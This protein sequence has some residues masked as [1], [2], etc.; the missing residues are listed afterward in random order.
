MIGI[1]GVQIKSE[2][3][4]G[5]QSPVVFMAFHQDPAHLF[6]INADVIRPLDFWRSAGG[7]PDS[8][9]GSEGRDELDFLK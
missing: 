2:P 5:C 6:A 7:R 9:D 1:G 4:Y 8:F 3:S